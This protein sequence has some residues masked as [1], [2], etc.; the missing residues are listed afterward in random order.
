MD[1]ATV[2]LVATDGA[3]GALVISR[4]PKGPD[5]PGLSDRDGTVTIREAR[6]YRFK[7]A[8]PDGILIRDG[9]PQLE[10]AELFD[11]DDATWMSGRLVPGESVGIVSVVVTTATGS[12]LRGRLDV[13]SAKFSDEQ[14]FGRMLADLAELSVEAMHQGFAPSSGEF[15]S[16]TGGSP[17]LLY[18][19]FAV[20]QS[21]L[22]GSDLEWAITKILSEPHRTWKSHLESRPLGRP[23][24]GSSRLGSQ[25]GRTGPRIG[26]PRGPLPSM[27]RTLLVERT[28]ETVDTTPNRFVRFVLERWR[29]IAAIV[30]LEADAL[31][32]AAKRRGVAQASEV[33]ALFDEYLTAPLF[34][35]VSRLSVFPGDNQVLRR[36]EGY[37][38]LRAAWA[39]VEGTVGLELDLED[40]LLV[41]RKSIASLYEYWTFIRLAQTVATACGGNSVVNDLFEPSNN[42]MSLVLKGGQTTHLKF[43]T[44]VGDEKVYVELFFNKTFQKS[45]WAQSSW[46][47]P[48][49]H[50]SWTRPMRPDAS[51]GMRT[52]DSDMVWLHF[53]AKYRVD[54]QTPFETGDVD[55]E[56]K[57]ERGSGA[58]KRADLLKMHAYRDAIR[59]SAG[60]YVL[61]PGST[62]AELTFSADEFLPGLGAFPLR[63][64]SSEDDT[65]KIADFITRA[66]AHVAARGTRHRRATYW[67][68]R[69]YSEDGTENPMARPP[70][71]NLPPADTRVL[72]GFV[73][74]EAQWKWISQVG[75][76]NL[77]AGD[78]PGAIGRG[79][80]ELDGQLMLLY[81]FEGGDSRLELY[82]RAGD[83]EAITGD[84]LRRLGYPDP[85]G[86][87]YLV[88]RVCQL[89]PPEWLDKVAISQLIPSGRLPGRPHSTTWLDLV[90]ST[91][92]AS[93][94]EWQG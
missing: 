90:L 85:K 4:L 62:P 93:Y 15:G 54:W 26:T 25:L 16:T 21:L 22:V 7:F 61:F 36:R 79:D 14:A 23:V 77:R 66:V 53:D 18:Q 86:D 89:E 6:P 33:V 37:R 57:A 29:A 31:G 1:S 43:E 92:D 49:P 19:Q 64:Q 60:S 44:V 55:E 8:I 13:R 87:A 11:S 73:R 58:S 69:A 48:M 10:P 78:R 30:V 76:Y 83:W 94:E 46:I 67:A 45:N 39:L 24:R 28:E 50:A 59:N 47:H 88:A 84:A 38:Q 68:A 72:L 74:T 80:Q 63:P 40:P 70:S 17:R 2:Q 9:I 5:G 91:Q 56:E 81:G 20:L 41:S 27:P 42:G 75:L 65:A 71:G 34:R 35:E 3:Y 12:V 32:G 82:K 51:L 52:P